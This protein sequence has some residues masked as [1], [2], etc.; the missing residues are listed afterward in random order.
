MATLLLRCISAM[1]AVLLVATLIG[2]LY[3]AW[4]LSRNR[5]NP[6]FWEGGLLWL[7]SFLVIIVLLVRA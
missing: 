2:L 3:G 5:R 1:T 4:R 6:D 7:M